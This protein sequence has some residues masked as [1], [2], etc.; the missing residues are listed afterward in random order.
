MKDIVVLWFR[1][2][3]AAGTPECI[4]SWCRK[5]IGEREIPVRRYYVEDNIECA[6]YEARFH[7]A[8]FKESNE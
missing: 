7:P 5:P 1:D 2:S 4:C 8:C 6:Q 3:P